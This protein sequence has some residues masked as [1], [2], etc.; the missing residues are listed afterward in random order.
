M[1][2]LAIRNAHFKFKTIINFLFVDGF[3]RDYNLVLL[4]YLVFAIRRMVSASVSV[5]LKF[6]I[7]IFCL[8]IDS[9]SQ[10]QRKCFRQNNCNCKRFSHNLSS[11]TGKYTW[12]PAL[13]CVCWWIEESA[14]RILRL[15][16]SVLWYL[17]DHTE[18]TEFDIPS[19]WNFWL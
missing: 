13:S 14:C 2:S 1:V 19:V 5:C 8:L 9:W 7:Y 4:R 18:K 10:L 12:P 3:L 16:K 6:E 11:F 15:N 17:G